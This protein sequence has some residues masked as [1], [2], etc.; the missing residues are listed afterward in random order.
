[1]KTALAYEQGCDDAW[2]LRACSAPENFD[3]IEQGAYE[4]G[5][6]ITLTDMCGGQECGN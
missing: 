4:R 1:M 3:E 6:K 5:Y 2:N